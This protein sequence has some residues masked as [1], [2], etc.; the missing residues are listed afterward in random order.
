MF[1]NSYFDFSTGDKRSQSL[2]KFLRKLQE[3]ADSPATGPSPVTPSPVAPRQLVPGQASSGAGAAALRQGQ[4]EHKE[5][6]E[7]RAPPTLLQRVALLESNVLGQEGMGSL[8]DRVAMLERV[9]GQRAGEG[10]LI[11]R[12]NALEELLR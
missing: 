7:P 2:P 3:E 6:A 10:I 12:V 11:T 1:A 5:E 9:V 8:V 4:E